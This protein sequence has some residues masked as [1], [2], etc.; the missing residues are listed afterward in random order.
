MKQFICFILV[1]FNASAYSQTERL[2]QFWNEYV[3]TKDLSQKWVI[4]VDG[5]LNSSSVP[6]DNNMFHNVT[7]IYFRGW[8]HYY[9][10]H[11]WK[12]SVFYAYY[13]NKNVPE[14]N[15]K[16]A[17]EFRTAVQVTYNLVNCQRSK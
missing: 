5:G 3:F 10:G 1:L 15:Q 6:Q 8:G 12:I 14:L 2:E 13:F 17:P 7:Q 4:E 9:L 11:R 16:K